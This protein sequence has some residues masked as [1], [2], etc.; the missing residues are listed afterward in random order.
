[1]ASFSRLATRLYYAC[2]RRA[3]AVYNAPV[4]PQSY[5]GTIQSENRNFK[6]GIIQQFN[7]N[8]E[9][10]LPGNVV[11]TVGYAGSRSA[12]ILVSQLN[13]NISSP[14]ALRRRSSRLQRGLRLP[15]RSL[16][17]RL[18]RASTPTTASARPVTILCRSRLKP[19]A[20]GTAST[21]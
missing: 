3:G 5:T 19:R 18:F 8:V 20:R 7:L 13:E 12:H 1:M 15:D 9:R 21:L 17:L 11:L 16:T 4:N 6:Q 14:S 2:R 10:Q